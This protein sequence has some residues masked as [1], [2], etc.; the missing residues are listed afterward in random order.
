M[1]LGDTRFLAA[2]EDLSASA[3][4]PLQLVVLKSL[5]PAERSINRINRMVLSA[6]LLALIC[7]TALMI[8]LSR[9]VTRPLEE[10][11]KSVKAFGTGDVD[12]RIPRH[13]TQEVLELSAA[14][15]ACA[16]RSRQ[17]NRAVLESERLATIG[18]MASSVSHDFRHYL[19]TIYANAEFLASDQILVKGAR[20]NHRG[21]PHRSARNDGNDRVAP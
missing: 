2:T 5:E 12:H 14:F 13:G 11:S 20:R 15:A 4:S 19:A 8:T 21:H 3:S 10:L 16:T 18:R 1:K 9:L 6:G 17:A 7:G